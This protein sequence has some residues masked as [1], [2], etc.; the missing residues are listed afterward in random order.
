MLA[1][2]DNVPQERQG[3]GRRRWFADDEMELIVWYAETGAITG[4]Q[5]CY[6]IR[7]KEGAF[8]WRDGADVWHT[9]I[10]SGEDSPLH[11]RT[12]IMVSGPPDSVDKVVADFKV[13]SQMLAADLAEL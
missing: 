4:F 5:L 3:S 9:A 2:L 13:R 1:E 8:T 7:G 11:N 10:D 12:P 6:D